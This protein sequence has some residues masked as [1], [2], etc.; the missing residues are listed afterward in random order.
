MPWI[1]LDRQVVVV[2]AIHEEIDLVW[3][4]P[5]ILTKKALGIGN[6]EAALELE[7]LLQTHPELQGV[8]F[9]GSAGAYSWAKLSIGDFVYSESFSSYSISSALGISKQIQN[10]TI[11]KT[12]YSYF[13][14]GYLLSK[15]WKEVVTNCPSEITLNQIEKPPVPQWTQ[16]HAE[17]MES[18]GVARVCQKRKI[19]FLALFAITN[20]VGPEGSAQWKKN[21]RKQSDQIQL[22]F[23]KLIEK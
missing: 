6:L 19:P 9:I 13:P 22:E 7:T 18:Y 5:P 8:L 21:W 12:N 4:K 14:K 15:N 3:K 20:I 11:S 23:Q 1:P 2:S 17:N 10:D 16:F